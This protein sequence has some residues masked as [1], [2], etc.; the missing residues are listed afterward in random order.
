SNNSHTHVHTT[1]MCRTHV[2][3]VGVELAA[4]LAGKFG[5]S[6]NIVLLT[7]G[8]KL[9][10]RMPDKA[11]HTASRWLRLAGVEVLHGEKVVQ[12]PEGSRQ[13][14]CSGTLVTQSG[15]EISAD[16]I[17]DCTGTKLNTE[18]YTSV[19]QGREGGPEAAAE[20]SRQGIPVKPT[21]E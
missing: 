17:I 9:L 20:A 11:G 1:A 8:S 2:Y 3:A 19:V 5:R 4:E 14:M 7:S 13:R 10:Q 6:K 21:L 15:R 12:W 16:R 18:L